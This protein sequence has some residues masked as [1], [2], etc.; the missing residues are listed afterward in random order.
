MTDVRFETPDDAAGVRTVVELAFG[1][2]EEADLVDALRKN[3]PFTL[4]LVAIDDARVVGHILFSPVTVVSADSSFEAIGLAPMAV[5]PERQNE[6]IGAALVRAGLDECR[7]RGETIVFVLG[8]PD[9]YPRFGFRPTRPFGIG[10]EYDV[11]E[12]VFMVAELEPGALAG[13]TGT[14]RYRPEFGGF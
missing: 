12:E 4:S 6:G 13:R 1:R 8:H 10:C 7:Q 11:P 2:P 9:Y 5:L 14:V 3:S